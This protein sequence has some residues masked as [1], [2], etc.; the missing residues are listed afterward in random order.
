MTDTI[1]KYEIQRRIRTGGFGAV[2]EARDP[3]LKRRVAIKT[4]QIPDEEIQTRFFREAELAGSLHHRNITTIYDSGIQNGMPYLVQEFLDGE[5]LD[6]LIRR[7]APLSVARK[8]EI[9][10]GV[11]YG[12]E[13]AHTAG[14]VHRDIKPSNMRVLGDGTVKIMDFGIAKSLRGDRDLTDAGVTVGTFSYLAPEQIRGERADQRTDIYAFGVLAYELLTGHRPFIGETLPKLFDEILRGKA[15]S[16]TDRSP[17]IPVRL[18]A[19]VHR[20]MQNSREARHESVSELRD[21]LLAVQ[22]V[23]GKETSAAPIPITQISTPADPGRADTSPP[24]ALHPIPPPPGVAPASGLALSPP[25]ETTMP[26][27]RGSRWMLRAAAVAAVLFLALSGAIVLLWPFRPQAPGSDAGGESSAPA[28]ARP[29]PIR[30]PEDAAASRSESASPVLPAADRPSDPDRV[31]AASRAG[32]LTEGGDRRMVVRTGLRIRPVQ[33]DPRLPPDRHTRAAMEP[34]LSDE[35]RA[36]ILLQSALDRHAAGDDYGARASLRAAFALSPN[37]PIAPES[38]GP[39]FARL[40]ETVRA[41][42]AAPK[43]LRR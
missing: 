15:Q 19:V 2:Y 27:R 26:G 41:N 39:R 13:H 32:S 4:C 25:P 7:G 8:L 36:H 11:A 38:Y 42:R 17:E 3:M 23:V 14:I 28:S 5:D 12:L 24:F 9:L 43:T 1:G 35:T 20:A 30:A 22:G 18:A 33:D 6:R 37:L 34:G 16:I 21:E 31:A 40:A 29:A 10:I